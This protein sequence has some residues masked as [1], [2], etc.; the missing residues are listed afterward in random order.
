MKPLIKRKIE[1]IS[2]EFNEKFP[3][4]PVPNASNVQMFKPF[5]FTEMCQLIVESIDSFYGAPFTI[6]RLCELLTCPYKH[7]K[8]TDK[9][10]RALEKNVL[11]VSTTEPR[12]E[13]EQNEYALKQK[14]A[15]FYESST[16]LYVE[17]SASHSNYVNGVTDLDSQ[18][19][20]NKYTLTSESSVSTHPAPLQQLDSFTTVFASTPSTP[21]DVVSDIH[22]YDNKSSPLSSESSDSN[23]PQS[24]G[25][26]LGSNIERNEIN[27][28]SGTEIP[29]VIKT[30]SLPADKSDHVLPEQSESIFDEDKVKVDESTEAISPNTEANNLVSEIISEAVE[31]TAKHEEEM[32]SESIA[33]SS[34][35]PVEEA[36]NNDLCR[37]RLRPDSPSDELKQTEE[38]P[39]KICKLETEESKT[40]VSEN[41]ENETI[42]IPTVVAPLEPKAEPVQEEI[43]TPIV[44]P[45]VHETPKEVLGPEAEASAVNEAKSTDCDQPKPDTCTESIEI[46]EAEKPTVDENQ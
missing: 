13:S 42:E 33:S 34:D 10:M 44:E 9:F 18:S 7:Y 29:F 46:N 40:H 39:E 22:N 15:T 1:L 4:E 36:T 20:T 38:I 37:K 11:V 28:E 45:E 43:M 41:K 6:Q 17:A 32:I 3:Y 21:L 8:R 14:S 5:Q 35:V 2:T 26:P 30:D 24:T 16:S 12:T 25:S 31:E 27:G 19:I 23:S